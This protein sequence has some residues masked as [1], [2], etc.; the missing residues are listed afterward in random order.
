MSYLRA[1]GVPAYGIEPI[2]EQRKQDSGGPH[3]DNEKI[4]ENAVH[5]FV[6]YQFE[7]VLHIAAK[8]F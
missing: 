5:A 1:K 2:L 6:R 4:E 7:L 3:S 8:S